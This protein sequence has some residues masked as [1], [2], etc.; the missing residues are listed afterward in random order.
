MEFA[1]YNNAAEGFFSRNL[2]PRGDR[3]LGF[4]AWRK[5]LTMPLGLRNAGTSASDAQCRLDRSG[6]L[7]RSG[8]M[9]GF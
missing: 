6:T 5:D 4:V 9:S 3:S 8:F 2:S 7:S 1:A